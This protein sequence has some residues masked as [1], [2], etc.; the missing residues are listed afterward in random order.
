MF[1]IHILLNMCF[2]TLSE[3]LPYLA[4]T[5]LA[6]TE[7]A[8]IRLTT[9]IPP[10][11]AKFTNVRVSKLRHD[12]PFKTGFERSPLWRSSLKPAPGE[13]CRRVGTTFP[14]SSLAERAGRGLDLMKHSQSHRSAG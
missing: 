11:A 5:F 1:Q 3:N 13:G 2:Y 4:E 10:D 9:P 8:V 6:N 7:L 12:F 14:S